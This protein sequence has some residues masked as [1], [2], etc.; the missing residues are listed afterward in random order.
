MSGIPE[1]NRLPRPKLR[2]LSL[3]DWVRGKVAQHGLTTHLSG[4]G[5]KTAQLERMLGG[6]KEFLALF[7]GPLLPAL[8]KMKATGKRTKD[9]YPNGEGAR[10]RANYGVLYFGGFRQLVP[11]LS[12]VEI[13]QLLDPVLEAGVIRTGLALI[14]RVCTEEQFQAIDRLGQRWTCERCDS[15]NNLNM[16][17]WN[18]PEH[19]SIWSYDL[20]PVGRQVLDEHGE[21]PAALASYLSLIE[22]C[23]NYQ[24]ISEIYLAKGTKAQAELDVVAYRDDTLIIGEAKSAAEIASTTKEKRV[25]DVRK[26]CLAAVWLQADELVFGTSEP[27]WKPNAETDIRQAIENFNWSDIGRPTV[28]LI[29]GLGGSGQEVSS[30]IL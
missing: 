30:R 25:A 27:V 5:H 4:A 2:D 16:A 3:P 26:K 12:P 29:S 19:E 18:K 7:A 10:I 23:K 13:R 20:H 11:G 28:R 6:R 9:C 24:D 1:L 17:A 14:C 15:I 22:G 21:V 8:R